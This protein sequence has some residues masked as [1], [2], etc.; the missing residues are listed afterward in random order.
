MKK[1]TTFILLFWSISLMAQFDFEVTGSVT[2]VA[3]GNPVPNQE[4]YLAVFDAADSTFIMDDMTLTDDAG[5]YEYEN[6]LDI[7][8]ALLQVGT[9]DCNGNLVSAYHMISPANNSVVQDFE[10]CTDNGGGGE[11]HAEFEYE[12]SD[13]LTIDFVNLSS[14]EDLMYYWDF[15]DGF[16]AEEENPVHTYPAAGEYLVTLYIAESDSSCFDVYEDMVFVEG[17]GGGECHAF[18]TYEQDDAT[19][20]FTDMSDGEDLM[21]YWTFGDGSNSQEENPTHTYMEGGEYLVTLYIAASDSSC[22]DVYE[23]MVSVEG[24]SGNCHAYF[25]YEQEEASFYFTNMSDGE[26]LMYYWTFGD[27]SNS[28]EENPTHTYME[29]GEYLVT[30]YIAVSDSSC[31]DVYDEMVYIEGGSGDCQA[32]Y[33]YSEV[34]DLTFEFENLS[35]G[36]DLSYY[37]TFGDGTDSE[38]ENPTHTYEYGGIYPVAL[39]IMSGDSTCFDYYED[40][41][42][43]GDSTQGECEAYFTYEYDE[44]NQMHV[45]FTDQSTGNDGMSPDTWVWDFGDGTYS[46]EQNPDHTYSEPGVFTVCLAIT[47]GDSTCYDF[48]CEPILVDNGGACVAQFTYFPDSSF[49]DYTYQF[50]DLSYGDSIQSWYWD[51]GDGNYSTEQNP[52]HTFSEEG[53][54]YVC[55]TIECGDC[56]SV[57][58]EDV[59]VGEYEDCFNYFTYESAGNSVLF[60]GFHSGEGDVSYYWE[61]GD[62]TSGEGQTTDHTYE[63]TG[64]YYVSLS[65]YDE[66]SCYAV[67][68]QMVVVGDS[69]MYHQVYGQVLEGSFPIEEGLVMIFSTDFGPNYEPYFDMTMI[70]SA[71][72]YVFPY[73]PNGEFYV[74]AVPLDFND[75]L[76]TYYGDVINWDEATSIVLGEPENPYDI[77]LVSAEGMM[78]PGSGNIDGNIAEGIKGEFI[79]KIQ[80]LLY[81]E[82]H[83]VIGFTDVDENGRFNLSNLAYGTYY[84]YA[85]LSGTNSDMIKVVLTNDEPDASVNM[86]MSGSTILGNTETFANTEVGEVYPN[87][88]N[89]EARIELT[90]V[91]ETNVKV[92]V[93]DMT[94]RSQYVREYHLNAGRS[95]INI[96][97]EHLIKGMYIVRISNSDGDIITRKALRN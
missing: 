61:F 40:I 80:V 74:Y 71:G 91:K 12:Q 68:G 49:T 58:C 32:S 20:V 66:D 82:S 17:A 96:P 94:G 76:P 18:F 5:N 19:F 41:V 42:M 26:D 63:E 45:F 88:T 59:Y 95:V 62:G 6:S 84:V 56:E 28:Q 31:F 36:E 4:I 2:D 1:L 70:D 83:E 89:K 21:Y 51:F 86:T 23:E 81:N 65:T 25:E 8:V 57:W 30:L 46:T 34:G 11:C 67:S 14:G 54:Y 24:G 39:F 79:D 38:E 50:V 33:T 15:G 97:M 64:T 87:P 48:Y 16:T 3:N 29:G 22:F 37:W 85:E 77:N 27:G 93:I 13:N 69:I 55:L 44:E 7:G 60:E 78:N 9:M 10:I 47:S 35:E 73:V 92:E 52:V 43:A 75:Y 90:N 72:I 53:D